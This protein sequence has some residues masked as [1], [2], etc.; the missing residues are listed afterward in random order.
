MTITYPS[1]VPRN[2]LTA[3]FD[4]V[5]SEADNRLIHMLNERCVWDV[6]PQR[7]LM[8][9]ERI[10]ALNDFIVLT[11]PLFIREKVH[12][13]VLVGESCSDLESD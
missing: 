12:P 10:Y 3:K 8:K 4:L 6:D 1:D 5:M 9:Q 11:P 7:R 13:K 2:I